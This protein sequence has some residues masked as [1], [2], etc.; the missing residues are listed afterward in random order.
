MDKVYLNKDIPDGYNYAEI[1]SD[2][3]RLYNKPSA[4]N[5]TLTCYTIYYNYSSDFVVE[6]TKTFSNYTTTFTPVQTSRSVFDRPDFSNIITI[7]F[8][9]AVFGVWL[10]NIFTSFFKK[11]GFFRWAFI[12]F[13]K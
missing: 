13:I 4:R 11:G 7:V 12:N 2:Y 10:L 3:I 1:T 9:I 5:E 6:S 8:I